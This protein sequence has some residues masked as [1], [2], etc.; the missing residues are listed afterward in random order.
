MRKSQKIRETFLDFFAQKDHKI[1]SSASLIPKDDPTLLFTNAGMNQFKNVFLGLED[2]SYSRAASVQKCMRASGKHNDLEQVGKTNKH[3]TFFEMLGNFSFG[4]YFKKEAIQYSWE[5][6]TKIFNLEKDRLYITVYEEDEEAF[7]LWKKDVGVPPD[8]IYGMGKEHNYWAMGDTGPCGPC[9][10]IHYDLDPSLEK[11]DP[12][13]L[14]ES[15]SDRFLELWNLVFMQYY[16]DEQGNIHPLPSPSID[17]GMGLER[18]ATVLQGKKTNYET[19][20]FAPLIEGVCEI[21]SKEYPS[22]DQSDISVRI[23]SDHIR[24]V[25]FLIGD[26][27]TPSNEGRGY[28]LRRLI[29][30]AFRKGKWL[31]IE[32]PFLYRMVSLVSDIMKDTYPELISSA[33]Y[34]SNVCLSEEKRFAQT[35]HSGMRVFNQYIEEVKKKNRKTLPGDKLFKLYDTFG[36]PVDLSQEL[37]AERGMNVD[38]KGFYRELE[39]QRE[40]ARRSWKGEAQKKE[41]EIYKPLKE[42]SM[43]YVGYETERVPEAK[44]ISIMKNGQQVQELKK[45]ASGEIFLDKTPFYAEAGGQIGDSGVLK[46][47]H[48]SGIVENTYSPVPGVMAHQVKGVGGKISVGDIVEAS[49]DRQ[50]RKAISQNHTATHLL[51]ASLRYYLGDHVKQSGSLVSPDRL[52]F[53]FTHYSPLDDSEIREI[54]DLINTKIREDLPVQ[55]KVTTL[56]EGIKEGAVAIFEEKYGEKVRMITIGDFSKE[57]C[58]GVHVQSTGEIGLFKIISETSIAAGMRRL[59]AVTGEEAVKYTQEIEGLLN[60]LQKRLNSPREE[61]LNQVDKLKD[62]LKSKEKENKSLRQKLAHARYQKS[63]DEVKKIKGVPVMVQE[64]KGLSNN[65][66]RELADSLKQ[67]LGSGIVVLGTA[68][69]QK[70]FL[71]TTV[72]KDLLD[73]IK[74]NEFIKKIAP[75]VEG[76]GGGRP[77][78]AQA[79]GSKPEKLNQ[80]LQK[81][82]NI[83]EQMLS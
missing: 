35:L 2:R 46:N 26:G 59:E 63:E 82:Y 81:S 33:N 7:S 55:T 42:Y 25:A 27:V 14:I 45:G 54:E 66:L 73:R 11:G 6:M 22:H 40:K 4:D 79:G 34:I 8:K 44:V 64:V 48:F 32:E 78:F 77:D 28:I 49:V 31:G 52:R 21:C 51:H 56:E 41:K 16:Q 58:G 43:E 12:Q 61:I 50:R 75:I 19:D 83:L 69:D 17:T 24:A 67:K 71:V 3:H 13:S 23:I 65:E 74:A 5:L 47:P 60:S 29:R 37:A 72:T 20:L 9:S 10:E 39:K 76:G 15:G 68:R 70:V 57:L 18:M 1:V 80:S 38:Q 36:F 62:S 30:R 53:D